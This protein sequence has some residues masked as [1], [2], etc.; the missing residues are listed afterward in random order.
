MVRQS[1]ADSIA[2]AA[3]FIESKGLVAVFQNDTL[4]KNTVL[5]RLI[6]LLAPQ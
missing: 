6:T 3:W 5:P 4:V 2:K 1:A